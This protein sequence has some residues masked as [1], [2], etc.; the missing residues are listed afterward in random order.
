M[1]TQT[2]GPAAIERAFGQAVSWGRAALIA[3]LTAGYP[4]VAD[5]LPLVRA[6]ADGGAD[7]IEV[8][9]PFSD[10][11]ADG[12]VIQ[13]ASHAALQ[14]G[15]TPE[16]CLDLAIQI[17]VSGVSCPLMLMGYYN[18]IYTFG[19]AAYARRCATAGVDGLIVPDLPPE[20]AGALES[21]CRANEVAL[22]YLV[23]PT[24]SAERR[25]LI[26]ARTE[27]FLYLVSRLG[28][29][30]RGELPLDALRKQVSALRPRAHTPIAVGFGVSTPA[31]ARAVAA[32][33]ADGVIVG[34]AIVERAAD[35]PEALRKYASSLRAALE[36]ARPSL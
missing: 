4:T 1:T 25:A 19:P 7:I 16:A 17:R 6:L 18:P 34:S 8:G 20:E 15:I 24:S 23:A 35:G 11:V 13:R 29:T 3:Y 27:G 9:V 26:A 28:I 22:I 10:P 30:G 12:P 14:A 33:G 2:R 21:A 5:S 32:T 36:P 31:Q